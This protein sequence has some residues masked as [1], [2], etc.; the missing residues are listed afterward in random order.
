MT[1]KQTLFTYRLKQAEETLFD[2][3]RMLQ[4]NLSPRS[5]TNRAYYSM[6]YAVLALF[7]KTDVALKTSKHTGVISIFDKEFVHTGKIDKHYSKILHKMFDLR[8]EGDYKEL[9]ALSAEDTVESV[10]LAKEFLRAIKDFM[11]KKPV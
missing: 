10:R 9:V 8:Q 2:A 5:I 11:G 6:F 1:D 3:E 7:L 4:D